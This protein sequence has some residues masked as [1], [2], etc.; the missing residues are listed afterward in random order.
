MKIL[1]RLAISGII[2]LLVCL[3]VLLLPYGLYSLALTKG[4]NSKYIQ[5]R[6]NENLIYGEKSFQFERV[7]GIY[8]EDN[9]RWEQ[10]G[11]GHFSVPFPLYHP[12]FHLNPILQQDK[13]QDEVQ[14]GASYRDQEERNLLDFTQEK[15][16]KFHYQ[17]IANHQ[18][19]SLPIFKNYILSKSNTEI[20]K[21]LFTKDLSTTFILRRYFSHRSI[22]QYLA[23]LLHTPYRELVY[24]LFIYL[25]RQEY[26]PIGHSEITFLPES[27][28]GVVYLPAVKGSEYQE[29]QVMVLRDGIIFK[30]KLRSRTNSIQAEALRLRVIKNVFYFESTEGDAQSLYARYKT[31]PYQDR[32]GK[33]G[34]AYLYAAW[35]HVPNDTKFLKELIYFLER[36]TNNS[37]P[38][39]VLY[40]YAYDR[41]GNNFSQI[42]ERR[43]ESHEEK[44]KRLRL[45]QLEAEQRAL[46]ERKGSGDRDDYLSDEEKRDYYLQQA[47][48]KDIPPEEKNEIQDENYITD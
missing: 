47:K 30:A 46:K 17:F 7:K 36:G 43:R 38:L 41:Y 45:E 23:D 14:F 21:D 11:L 16:G 1:I 22:D 12:Q 33:V 8:Y 27:K 35:S 32:I 4:F 2:L 48:D 42:E 28:T 3:A 20:W 44:M 31:F 37:V 40:Q 19:F 10:V 39:Q 6:P 5:I 29:E 34:M 24:G 15:V 26:L 9:Q 13:S 25:L 18:L